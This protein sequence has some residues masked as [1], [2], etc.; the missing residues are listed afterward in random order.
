MFIF[1]SNQYYV[2]LG[3]HR[4][5]VGAWVLCKDPLLCTYSCLGLSIVQYIGQDVFKWPV[6]LSFLL[7]LWGQFTKLPTCLQSSS[8][9]INKS[10][11]IPSITGFLV[12]PLLTKQ[13]LGL[14]T[15]KNLPSFKRHI[16][17]SPQRRVVVLGVTEGHH[18]TT[19]N[20]LWI[21]GKSLHFLLLRWQP[22][23]VEWFGCC[24]RLEVNASGPIIRIS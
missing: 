3:T 1:R 8:P 13:H 5:P 9:S 23:A 6:F 12:S 2:H 14:S 22:P 16:P 24:A 21:T 15:L 20:F 18:N 19:C 10:Q 4:S 17:S 11:N 7:G